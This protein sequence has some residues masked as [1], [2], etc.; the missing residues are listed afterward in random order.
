MT[1]RRKNFAAIP[2]VVVG[3]ERSPTDES[4]VVIPVPDN[5]TGSYTIDLS[6]WLARGIDTW[7]IAVA[8][9]LR[10]FLQAQSVAPS[11]VVSYARGGMA[12]WFEFLTSTGAPYGPAEVERTNL[13]EFIAWLQQDERRL[14]KASQKNIYQLT[15]SVLTGM[16]QRS[17]I[18]AG[19]TIFP[20]N[21]FPAVNAS[22]R[23]QLPLSDNERARLADAIRTDVIAQHH[24]SFAGSN[25]QALAVHALALALRTGLNTTPLLELR[26]DCLQPHP[27]MPRMR[28]LQTFKRRG[29]AT[30]LKSLRYSR[31]DA[32]SSSVPMDGVALL[33]SVLQRTAALAASAPASLKD[34]VWLYRAEAMAHRGK[35]TWMSESALN[36]NILGFV[37]RHDLR[38]DDGG[39][40]QLN[41][42]R[43][44]K[45]MENR[46]WRLSNGDLFTVAAIMGHA[47]RVADQ[48]YLA[49]TPEMRAQAAIVGEALPAMYRGGDAAGDLRG[50]TTDETRALPNATP[51]GRC[52]DSLDG[53][54]A[55]K[56]GT[57]CMDFLSCFSCRSYAVVGEPDDLHRLFSFYWFL[58][59]ER[60][61]IPSRDWAEHFGTIMSQIDVFTLEKFD[62]A[63][64]ADAKARAQ[65]HPL[66][67]WRRGAASLAAGSTS[68]K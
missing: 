8:Q 38:G 47:P 15:K 41:T 61:K 14:R 28:L 32:V 54:K 34:R 5:A 63:T 7:V 19:A 22:K 58:N 20:R 68:G 42:S 44:R 35:L 67:F 66:T 3:K 52:K 12:Y 56:D 57:H 49:V 60:S 18:R 13:E 39:L 25:A 40:L 36:Y 31:V 9:Q 29:N 64:V 11:T 17:V 4:S 30:Q 55:P 23:G 50:D 6:R 1:G 59:E 43:L 26:R 33:E 2:P 65:S 51:V 10:A 48:S 24:G 27:F 21:P 45:T 46:L 37:H 53:D 16:V 62:Y